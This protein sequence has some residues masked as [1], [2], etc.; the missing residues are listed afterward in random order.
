MGTST[1]I[2]NRFSILGIVL[3]FSIFINLIAIIKQVWLL[4]PSRK[5][6]SYIGH[7]HPREAPVKL[8]T[9]NLALSD[10][11]DHYGLEGVRAVAEWNALH[12]DGQG[13]VYLG[14]AY[15]DGKLQPPYHISMFHQLQCLNHIRSAYANENSE[16]ERT[17]HCV[18]Y[19]LQSILCFADT[20]LEEGGVGSKKEDGSVAAPANN[21]THTCRDWSQLYDYTA[22]NRAGW[23]A[24]QVEFEAELSRGTLLEDLQI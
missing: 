20:T 13:S 11:P 4:S 19:L 24:E 23:M 14:D 22:A 8:R 10:D 12:P 17:A 7:D 15:V 3:A 1:S 16:P 5:S 2:R 21:N 9:V 18:G 6:Y